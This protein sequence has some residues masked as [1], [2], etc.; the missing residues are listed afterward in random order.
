MGLLLVAGDPALANPAL[1]VWLTDEG[2][3]KVRV[4]ECEGGLCSNI[5]WL[6]EPN[7]DDGKPL[8]DY[9]NPDPKLRNRKIVGLPLM[10]GLKKSG[11]KQWSGHI[12][13]PENGKTYQAHL[14]LVKPNLIILKGCTM[15]GWPCGRKQWVRAKDPKPKPVVV[16]RAPQPQPVA[17]PAPAPAARP[18]PAPQPVETTQAIPQKRIAVARTAPNPVPPPP[19]RTPQA[20]A[21]APQAGAPAP[22]PESVEVANLATSDGAGYMV[23]VAARKSPKAAVRA[24]GRL[25]RRFPQILGGFQP[26]V[27]KADLGEKGVWYRLRVGPMPERTAAADLCRRLRD[28]GGPACFVRRQ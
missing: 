26:V 8:R 17:R 1:G 6:R 12:Y 15:W 28:A 22:Q 9:Y 20:A 24:F 7:D 3:A 16:A 19:A 4:S 11:D 5:V 25:Q 13:N 14:T 27:Q 21:P 10:I 2:K 18:Q 23:Q